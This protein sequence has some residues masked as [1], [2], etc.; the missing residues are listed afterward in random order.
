MPHIQRFFL[1]Q[2]NSEL[3]FGTTVFN[4]SSSQ[5][6][7][8]LLSL[9]FL[10]ISNAGYYR[11]LKQLQAIGTERWCPLRDRLW[12]LQ[13]D[14]RWGRLCNRQLTYGLQCR[15]TR[16]NTSLHNK[17]DSRKLDFKVLQRLVFILNPRAWTLNADP[18]S[19][20]NNNSQWC[21]WLQTALWRMPIWL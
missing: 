16:K 18:M 2:S 17:T 5:V 12:Q 10:M 19:L 11:G 13:T 21:I 1:L 7:K 15:W 14:L 8:P 4:S 3:V 20:I 6:D 9:D